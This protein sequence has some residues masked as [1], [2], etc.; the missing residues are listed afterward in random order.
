[1]EWFHTYAFG[2]AF[3]FEGDHKPLEQTNLKNLTEAPV[4]LQRMLLYLQNYDVIIK[5]WLGKEMLVADAFSCYAPP[6][7]PEIPLDIVINQVHIIP[8]KTEFQAAIHNDPL[9][10]SLANTNLTGLPED[11]N[12]VPNPLCPYHTH[13]DLL[14]V[15][16]GFSLHGKVL[17]IPPTEREKVL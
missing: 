3:S 16:D 1:M 17:I 4:C 2:L 13:C 14:T 12:D 10:H 8:Q 5:Y 7:A 9:L 15:E 11:I 6:D